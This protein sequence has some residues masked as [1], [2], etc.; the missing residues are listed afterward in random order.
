MKNMI[1]QID[2]SFGFEI[3]IAEIVAIFAIAFVAKII[4]SYLFSYASKL[5][6]FTKNFWDDSLVE[7]AEK[8]ASALIW[9]IAFKLAIDVLFHRLYEQD[10][11][12]DFPLIR[13]TVIVMSAW[14]LIRLINFSSIAFSR[15]EKF[16]HDEF[17]YTTLEA[18]AKLLKLL[19]IVLAIIIVMQTVG[20][21]VSGILAAGGA[22]G[23]VLGFAAK[24]LLAN[25]FGGLTIYLD[26][27]FNVGDWVRCKSEDIEG[28]VEKIGWRQTRIRAFNRNPIYVPN[29]IFTNAV[30][31]NPSRMTHR[32]INEVI[33]LRYNDISKMKAV[34]DE[35]REML[36]NHKDIDQDQ[37]VIVNFDKFNDSS[38][39]FFITAFS[40]ITDRA[41]FCAIKEDVL[42]KIA[43]IIEKQ[44]AEIAF[45]TRTLYMES[46]QDPK[47]ESED[48]H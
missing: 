28:N 25:F 4:A 24:D 8:P 9:L 39:D 11:L 46:I 35:V 26:R 47:S 43:G 45:P 36:K 22:G 20:F 2:N 6:Q 12:R 42:L 48:N 32:R 31:E 13:V 5:T 41:E 29:A 10:F 17:N 7:S 34:V 15:S 37:G 27:P 18:I 40:K 16:I 38:L 30:V 1:T 3:W 33:G 23:L 44:G 19:V 14:F 21:S